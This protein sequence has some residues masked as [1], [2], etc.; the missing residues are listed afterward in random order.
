MSVRILTS[1]NA[2]AFRT[3]RLRALQEHPE[4]F[5]SSYEEDV[6]KALGATE[7]RIAAEGNVFWG[8]FIDGEIRG[9]IGLVRDPRAKNRHKGDVVAMYVEPEF[10]RHGLGRALL[11]AVIDY[12][13]DAEKLEQLVLTVTRSNQPAIEL[14]RSARF[15]TFGM[16][17]RALKVGSDYF[18]KEHM[19]L[20]L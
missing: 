3:L 7:Q 13:R 12:A 4:A 1:A 6:H 16:E 17:P 8:A 9:M 15:R 19:I 10:R 5:T 14:Y 20:F 18:D 11:Q 2:A